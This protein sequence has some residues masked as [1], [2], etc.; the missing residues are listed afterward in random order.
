[1]APFSSPLGGAGIL[2]FCLWLNDCQAVWRYRTSV[3][4][5]F[6]F[7]T[8]TTDVIIWIFDPEN[9]EPS[10]RNNIATTPPLILES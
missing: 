8:S 10:E 3:G 5:Y 9:A 2:L 1:M 4:N 7:T 6:L